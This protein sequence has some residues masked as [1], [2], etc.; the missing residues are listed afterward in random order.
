MAGLWF[1]EMQHCPI[2]IGNR[3]LR[4]DVLREGARPSFLICMTKPND[5]KKTARFHEIF[6]IPQLLI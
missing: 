5:G 6:F 3:P 2:T 4:Q 1:L